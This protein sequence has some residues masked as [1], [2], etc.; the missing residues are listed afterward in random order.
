MVVDDTGTAATGSWEFILY[1]SGESRDSNDSAELPGIDVA[2]GLT[3]N[4][5]LS[6]VLPRQVSDGVTVIDEDTVP[7]P[8][9]RDS[10][11]GTGSIGWK[12]RFIESGSHALAFAPAFS[13]PLSEA[14]QIRGLVQDSYQLDIPLL[15][16]WTNGTWELTGQLGYSWFSNDLDNVSVGVSAGFQVNSQLRL[17]GEAYA[18]EFGRNE[19]EVD[20]SNWRLGAEIDF[21]DKF[22]LLAAFG[23][24]I[25]SDLAPEDRLN[26]DYF[27]GLQWPVD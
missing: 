17:L 11:P 14:A 7:S 26:W 25:T 2:Y 4:M 27:I 3:H 21:G 5:E 24:R 13:F 19:T 20:F 23:G 12:W 1:S 22:R 10:G 15:A 6:M 16:S 9:R 8:P 18:V